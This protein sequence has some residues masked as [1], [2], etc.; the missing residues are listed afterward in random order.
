MRISFYWGTRR[1]FAGPVSR[2]KRFD[3]FSLFHRVGRNAAHAVSTVFTRW[4]RFRF[5]RGEQEATSMRPVS[6]PPATPPRRPTPSAHQRTP[7][8]LLPVA[9]ALLGAVFAI[10]APVA[11]AQSVT[12]DAFRDWAPTQAGALDDQTL[13][14]QRGGALGMVMVVATPALMRGNGVTLWDEIAP[15]TPQP[16]PMDASQSSQGNVANYTRR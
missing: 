9:A 10:A 16:V 15:P 5:E 3:E 13:A 11:H 1:N 4:H 14:R 12:A 7:R 6:R 8:R 2:V